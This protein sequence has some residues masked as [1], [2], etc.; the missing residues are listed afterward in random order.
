VLVGRVRNLPLVEWRPGVRTRLHAAGSTGAESLCVFEQLCE[1]G[2]GAPP[3]RHDGVEEVIVVL[4]GQARI[5]VSGE[6]TELGAG[7]SVVLPA[8]S[9]HGFRNIGSDV[10]RILAVFAAATPPVEYEDEP[11]VLEI[12]GR[13]L[14]RRDAHRAEREGGAR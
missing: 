10:L 3:H 8:G 5:H 13:G 6:E 12:G 9:R 14:K 2:A 1:P 7:E 11:G 4:E